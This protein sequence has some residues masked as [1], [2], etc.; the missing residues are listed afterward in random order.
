MQIVI[1][2]LLS[3]VSLATFAA[4]VCAQEPI[5]SPSA[6][7]GDTNENIDWPSP[8]GKFAFLAAYGEDLHTIDLIDRKSEKKL[9]RIDEADSSQTY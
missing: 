5:A 6:S 1:R 3:L 8:D 7:A 4:T 9:Q 2:L